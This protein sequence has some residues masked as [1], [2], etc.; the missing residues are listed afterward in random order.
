MFYQKLGKSGLKVSA[1]SLGGW[2]TFGQSVD[3]SETQ[4]C[5]QAA[6]DAGVNL[7]DGA[8]AY[9]QGAADEAM[10][11]AFAKFGWDRS[12]YMICGKVFRGG[13]RDDQVG[14]SKKRLT[15][16]CEASLRRFQTDYLELFI[17]HRP[18]PAT[19]LEE[20]VVTMNRLIDQGKILYWGTS[21]FSS[22]D[23]MEMWAIAKANGLDGPALEQTGYNMLGRDRIDNQLVPVIERYGMGSMIYSPLAGGILTGKYNNGIPEDSRLGGDGPDWLKKSLTDEKLEKSRKLGEIANELG[24]TQ[25]HL[26]LAWNLKNPRVSTCLTGATKAA[27]V[28]ENVKAVDAVEKITDDVMDRIEKILN[29]EDES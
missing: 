20:I 9:G 11:R 22:S 6:Y 25:A 8:E 16:A 17:C 15:D 2:M 24:V 14:L 21:E 19:P 28:E 29:P 12:T 5:L 13:Q 18:D 26:A 7:F 10:G 3:D 4:G 23:L 27:Q 1:I